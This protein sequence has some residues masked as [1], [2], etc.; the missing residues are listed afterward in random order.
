MNIGF[1]CTISNT[2]LG[3]FEYNYNITN[4]VVNNLF[5]QTPDFYTHFL[6]FVPTILKNVYTFSERNFLQKFIK[7]SD[8]SDKYQFVFS[9][10]SSENL[11]SACT[12]SERN[13][14]FPHEF[15]SF[16]YQV[17]HRASNPISLHVF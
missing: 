1:L 8:V 12:L 10:A 16:F 9:N 11:Q 4:E 2:S 6:M 14:N 13:F 15:I 3:K 7:I 5:Y 17:E